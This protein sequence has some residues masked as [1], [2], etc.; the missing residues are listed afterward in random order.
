MQIDTPN[1]EFLTAKEAGEWIGIAPRIF[2]KLAEKE[3][4]MRPV[5]FGLDGKRPTRK[6][7]RLDVWTFCYIFQRRRPPDEKS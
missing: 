2:V 7:S 4:W 1:K 6:W 5:L 3:D